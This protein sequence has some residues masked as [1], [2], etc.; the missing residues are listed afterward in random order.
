MK[1]VLTHASLTGVRIVFHRN[2]FFIDVYVN[3]GNADTVLIEM[4]QNHLSIKRNIIGTYVNCIC[5]NGAFSGT[6]VNRVNLASVIGLHHVSKALREV[7][8]VDI[9]K[10]KGRAGI[11]TRAYT[12]DLNN[13]NHWH[14]SPD[15]RTPP[16][17][18]F[19]SLI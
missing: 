5:V 14:Y 3:D 4:C 2:T 6:Y 18:R 8:F 15:G 13:Y 16:L 7:H 12:T 1:S 9:S 10:I 11:R 19:H 17:I